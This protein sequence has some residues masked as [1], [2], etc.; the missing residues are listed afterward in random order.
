MMTYSMS[1][2]LLTEQ[3][4]ELVIDDLQLESDFVG[5][6]LELE[7]ELVVCLL[8]TEFLGQPTKWNIH[9]I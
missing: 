1:R 7:P 2:I 6:D 9:I 3:E 4:A 8:V 5:D